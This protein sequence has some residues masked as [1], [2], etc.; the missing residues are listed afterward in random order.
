VR[1][2]SLKDDMRS[3]PVYSY[4]I[5]N[6]HNN[7]FFDI[8]SGRGECSKRSKSEKLCGLPVEIWKYIIQLVATAS[9]QSTM[10]LRCV[11]KFFKNLADDSSTFAVINMDGFGVGG[12]RHTNG[13]EA[14]RE[15]RIFANRCLEA[16]NPE[17]LFRKGIQVLVQAADI[18]L[19]LEYF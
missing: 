7:I 18:P 19:A 13:L 12:Y 5:S 16:K 1:N 3:Y 17:S 4:Q 8:M 6:R 11:S 9:L 2:S 14:E 10:E 15:V